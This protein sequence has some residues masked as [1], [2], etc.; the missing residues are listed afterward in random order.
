M[1]GLFVHGHDNWVDV[2]NVDRFWYPKLIGGWFIWVSPPELVH[3]VVE[4][5][6]KS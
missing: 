6:R 5:N 4:E 2:V 3:I 1:D